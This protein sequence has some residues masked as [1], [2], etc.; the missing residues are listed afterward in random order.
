MVIT[1]FKTIFEKSTPF[2]KDVEYA[3]KR[4]KEGNSK[5]L[6]E[7][8]QKE[9]EKVKQTVLKEQLPVIR[10]A[11][12][13]TKNNDDSLTKASGLI[14]LDFD[15]YDKSSEMLKM[16]KKLEKD[17]YSFAVFTSPRGNGLKLLVKIPEANQYTYKRYFESLAEYYNDVHFDMKCSNI[18]RAC[19]E[20]YDPN[21]FI[22]KDSELWTQMSDEKELDHREG[23]PVLKLDNES[24]IIKRLMKWFTSKYN[25][26]SGSRNNDIFILASALSDY[27]VNEYEA[28]RICSQYEQKDFSK[29]EIERTI[30][31][32]YKKG[33]A[34][35]GMKYFEDNESIDFIK[36]SIR[37]GKSLND[38]KKKMPNVPEDAYDKIK[39]SSSINDFWEISKNGKI[40]IRNIA[41]KH[42]LENNGFYKYYP[43]NS[44]TFIFVKIEN[45]LVDNTNEFKIKDYILDELMKLG[46]YNVYNYMAENPKLFKDD[47]LN[48]VEAASIGFMEDTQSEAYLYFRNGALKVT[49]DQVQLI[50]YIDLN[51]YVWKKHIINHDYNKDIALCDFSKF[52]DNISNHNKASFDSIASTIGYLLHSHKTSAKNVAVILNDEVISENP[53]GG[54]GKGIFI[55]AISKLKRI[56][57]I[58]G[59]TFSF[60]KSFP[61]Q[62]VSADTH[63]IVFD[64]VRKNFNFENLFSIVT[65][66]ITIEK[67]NKDAIKLP[68]DK[69]PKVLISTNY[70]VGGDGNSFERRKWDVEFSQHYNKNRTPVDD[71]GRLLFDEWDEKEWSKFYN[72]MISCLQYYLKYGLQKTEFKNIRE[73]N[74]IKITSF[75]FNEWVKDM[76]FEYN[77]RYYKR[78]LYNLFVSDYED[79]KK[80]VTQKR[81][82]MWL[83]KFFTYININ[84]DKDKDDTGRYIII[85]TKENEIL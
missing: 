10:F 68:I 52:I 63:I 85:K 26:S 31:S 34:N 70:A 44:D 27:G 29:S 76:S 74:F 84:V 28:N 61:Y 56:S 69:S 24:E 55:N 79:A 62:T 8:I 25:V 12:Q 59:K 14:I 13:F 36:N 11:G 41:Y 49:A 30:N 39:E 37:S 54:T 80:F 40:T 58:D 16:R 47:R 9:S 57:I 35:F 83:D 15:N 67:K 82:S 17:K 60:D 50:D 4:I 1:Y 33:K 48:I 3:F 75:E 46:Q 78:E 81:F 2:Y 66:G 38:I 18:S 6:I 7:S 71:F 51:G 53:N 5:D 32:A 72:F 73:R 77:K 21:I 65:E 20:S 42:W 45:N 19:F 22:N 23:S 64:D 43:D